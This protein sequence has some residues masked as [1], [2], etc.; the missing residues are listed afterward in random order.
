[1]EGKGPS[2]KGERNSEE[3]NLKEV[4]VVA[5]IGSGKGNS[6]NEKCM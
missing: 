1:M 6:H 4:K 5:V 2:S 3:E